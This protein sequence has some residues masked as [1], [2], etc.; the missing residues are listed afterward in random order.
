MRFCDVDQVTQHDFLKVQILDL[1][2]AV[3]QL[4][5]LAESCGIRTTQVL[6]S[7]HLSTDL[8]S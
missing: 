6:A 1:D 7:G 4:H 5:L 3:I 2:E 8:F